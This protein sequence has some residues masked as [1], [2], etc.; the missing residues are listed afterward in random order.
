MYAR[1]VSLFALAAFVTASPL[2]ER[3]DDALPTNIG[4]ILSEIADN[5]GTT[6]KYGS[7]IADAAQDIADDNSEAAQ[8]VS[9]LYNELNKQNNAKEAASVAISIATEIE[10]GLV[11]TE[12][13]EMASSFVSELKNS[14]FNTNMADNLDLLIE[15]V[16]NRDVAMPSGF[17]MPS[18]FDSL[19]VDDGES[20]ET[21]GD[22]EDLKSDSA[23]DNVDSESSGVSRIAASML[24]LSMGAILPLF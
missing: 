21:G 14:K 17:V 18:E 15:L 4:E 24:L 11:P 10:G 16:Q 5:I 6:Q 22:F 1:A 2:Q 23:G 20:S 9:S 7:I 13:T 8:I 12:V 19:E 3:K